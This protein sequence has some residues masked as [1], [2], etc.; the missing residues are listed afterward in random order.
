MGQSQAILCGYYGKGNSG[1]EALLASLIQML[2]ANVT[3]LV[4]SGNP[5]ETEKR[6]GVASCDRSSPVEIMR[7]MQRSQAFIWGGGSLIQDVTSALSPSYYIGLML[8]AQRLGL[9]TIAWAQGVGP[10]QRS[11]NDW[12]ARQ[13]FAGCTQVSVRDRGSAALL[14]KWGV[15]CHVAPDPVWGLQS[16]FVPNPLKIPAPRVAVALRPH[17]LLT[18]ERLHQLTQALIQFQTATQTSILLLPFHP[19]MDMQLAQSIQAVL[20]RASQILCLDDPRAM[21]GL[22][23]EVELAIAMRFH[24]LIMAAAEG[25]RCTAISY[26]PKV[27]QLMAELSLTGWELA[28]LPHDPSQISQVWLQQYTHQHQLATDQRQAVIHQALTHGDSLQAGLLGLT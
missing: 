2:P 22:F 25:C 19:S 26:D 20:P 7:A 9:K 23:R 3:P 5:A 6:Y 21:K 15:P 24:G 1:D 28:E 27:S 10:I 8:L 12:L 17:P 4:L 13:A 14:S 16:Q 18:A 11:W